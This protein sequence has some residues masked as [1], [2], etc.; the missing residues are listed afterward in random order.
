MNARRPFEPRPGSWE[1]V[2]FWGAVY[3]CAKCRIFG[4][5]LFHFFRMSRLK[6]VHFF[7][8]L[9]LKLERLALNLQCRLL[10]WKNSFASSCFQPR[11]VE[12][13]DEVNQVLDSAH[14]SGLRGFTCQN[15]T[16]QPAAAKKA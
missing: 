8:V 7:L 15:V 2:C 4:L 13:R 10:D 12:L 1:E 3:L 6:A 16:I 9:L 14:E 11:S 5:K